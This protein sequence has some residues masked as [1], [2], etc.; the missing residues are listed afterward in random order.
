MLLLTLIVIFL[1]SLNGYN[2]Q[3]SA[4]LSAEANLT[5]TL[6]TNYRTN[7]RP[8]DVVY[9]YVTISLKQIVSLDEKNQIMTSSAFV[10]QAWNDPRLTWDPAAYNGI[11]VVM[12]QAS[13]IWIPD[14]VVINTADTSG[15]FT[16]NTVFSYANLN[17][18]GSIYLYIPATSLKTRCSLNTANYPFDKQVCYLK[19][20]SWTNP[21]NRIQY[22]LSKNDTID[23]SDYTPN[24]VW[25]LTDTDLV[26]KYSG[27]RD[28]FEYSSNLEIDIKFFLSRKPLYYM[29]NSVLPC[30]ILNVVTVLTFF[31]PFGNSLGLCK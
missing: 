31:M 9:V 22:D 23:L 26:S 30:L 24:P 27:D 19:L 12:V 4:N 18:D 8:E 29:M 1:F 13:Q 6:F 10:S 3:L 17:Y 5:K 16:L 14:T 28:P 2:A 25:T 20:T 15:Y 21:V 7:I 11:E